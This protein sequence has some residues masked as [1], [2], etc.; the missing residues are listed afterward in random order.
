M[1]EQRGPFEPKSSIRYVAVER[2]SEEYLTNKMHESTL[3]VDLLI[4]RDTCPIM[5]APK[6]KPTL[7]DGLKRRDL[8]ALRYI[9]HYGKEGVC[10]T[11]LYGTCH[12]ATSKGLER[13]EKSGLI[14]MAIISNIIWYKVTPEGRALLKEW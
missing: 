1:S 2:K 7:P 12:N 11:Y 14:R 5:G 10:S 4:G 13:L 9:A 3:N 6:P 8:K